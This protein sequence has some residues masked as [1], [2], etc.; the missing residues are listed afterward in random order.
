VVIV[1]FMAKNTLGRRLVE[2]ERLVRIFGQLY[3]LNAEVAVFNAFSAHADQAGLIEY[4]KGCN[5]TL[6]SVYLVH[7]ETDQSEALRE[8]IKRLGVKVR[9]PGKDESVFLKVRK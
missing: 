7:G 6:N 9:V 3:E 8:K 1:G 5:D 2:K 4:I